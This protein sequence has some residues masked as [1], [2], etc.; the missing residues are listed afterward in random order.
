MEAWLRVVGDAW[1]GSAT[2]TRAVSTLPHTVALSGLLPGNYEVALRYLRQAVYSTSYTGAPNTWPSA[3]RGTFTLATAAPT[4]TGAVWS[5]TGSSAEQIAVTW[6]AGNP[7]L[8]AKI[9]WSA[10]NDITGATLL[11]SVAASGTY[12]HTTPTG[13]ADNYYWLR[14]VN[15]DTT[16]GPA[17]A[18]FDAWGGPPA[19]PVFVSLVE[20]GS[21]V[22]YRLTWTNGDATL[23]TQAWVKLNAGS[24]ALAGTAAAGEVEYLGSVTAPPVGGTTVR[25]KARHKATA[26]TVD[27]FTRFSAEGIVVI[28]NGATL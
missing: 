25:A 28:P 26:F 19:P 8:T 22:F 1:P 20:V 17:S 23:A 9:Y 18:S 14:H 3:S 2:A 15:V 5:R 13:E 11:S 10:T 21:S 27:D 12:T 6:T 7:G 16:L 4:I 24:Y